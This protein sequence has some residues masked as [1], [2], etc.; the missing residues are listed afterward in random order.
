MQLVHTFYHGFTQ[1]SIA[2]VYAFVR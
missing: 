1:H 2:V